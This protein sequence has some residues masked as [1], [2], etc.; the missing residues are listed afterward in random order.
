MAEEQI[1]RNVMN[2]F[3]FKNKKQCKHKM[4]LCNH[5]GFIIA[6]ERCVFD[7]EHKGAHSTPKGRTWVTQTDKQRYLEEHFK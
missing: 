1:E 5:V 3:K 2:I 4:T 6:E 7:A